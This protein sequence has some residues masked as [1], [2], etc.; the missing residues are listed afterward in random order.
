L[1]DKLDGVSVADHYLTS[2][3]FQQLDHPFVSAAILNGA[4]QRS[5]TKEKLAKNVNIVLERFLKQ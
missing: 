2:T 3:L 4:F 5:M 1:R